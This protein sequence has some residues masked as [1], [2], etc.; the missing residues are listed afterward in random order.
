LYIPIQIIC[1]IRVKWTQ[2]IALAFSLCLTIV[3]VIVTIIRAAGMH[4]G[5]AFDYAWVIYWQIISA[6]VGLVMTSATAFR[7][8]FVARGGN[9][10]SHSDGGRSSQSGSEQHRWS[11]KTKQF[12][13][14]LSTATMWQSRHMSPPA[15]KDQEGEGELKQLPPIHRGTMTGVRTFI[16]SRGRTSTGASRMMQSTVSEEGDDSSPMSAKIQVQHEIS[17]K[18]ERVR[19]WFQEGEGVTK[20]PICLCSPQILD[21]SSRPQYGREHV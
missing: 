19:D 4:H 5:E 7:A 12:F 1:R 10:N 13:R 16:N 17:S 8:F 6:E 15:G 3:V 18:S 11:G 21:D 20:A 9:S 2:K 14:R